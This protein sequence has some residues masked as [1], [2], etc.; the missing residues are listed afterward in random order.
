MAILGCVAL[1]AAASAGAAAAPSLRLTSRTP[2]TVTGKGFKGHE[3]LTVAV[4]V[5]GQGSRIAKVS[6]AA[7]GS[8]TESFRGLAAPR[9]SAVV[10]TVVRATGAKVR[11]ALAAPGC[12]SAG[13]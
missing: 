1:L 2:V 4:A 3:H 12:I 6:A 11:L 8:F 9:C 5:R 10:V 7:A 13:E